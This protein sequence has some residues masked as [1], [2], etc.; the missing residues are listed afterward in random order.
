MYDPTSGM[1]MADYGATP[2]NPAAP[3]R[4]NI[5]QQTLNRTSQQTQQQRASGRQRLAQALMNL[6]Q[7]YGGQQPQGFWGG[8]ASSFQPPAGSLANMFNKPSPN[9]ITGGTG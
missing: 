8:L 4:G 2:G 7:Q 5:P 9:P 6:G 1:T 3:P